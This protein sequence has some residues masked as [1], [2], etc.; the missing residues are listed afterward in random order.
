MPVA[1]QV[2]AN[3]RHV[4]ISAELVDMW[5]ASPWCWPSFRTSP[6]ARR[7]EARIEF[8]AHHDPLTSLPNRVL[9]RDRFELATAWAEHAGN[10]V[11]LLYLDL[12]HFKT[13]NDTLGHPVGD[14]IA[15]TSGA[16]PARCVRDTDTISRQGGDEFLDCTDRHCKT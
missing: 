4:S 14:Q 16:A 8:L 5:M 6:S 1:Q 10:K 3:M 13:I 7:P 2:M 12:D 11:A 9:F 15:A